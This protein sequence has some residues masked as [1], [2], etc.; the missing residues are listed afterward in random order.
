MKNRT[1]AYR[2]L[3]REIESIID[4]EDEAFCERDLDDYSY[5][6]DDDPDTLIR[7][8]RDNYNSRRIGFQAFDHLTGDEIA[9]AALKTLSKQ[10]FADLILKHAEATDC[11]IYVQ[12]NEVA[13]V[14]IGEYEYQI[15][16]DSESKLA[17]LIEACSPEERTDL[18]GRHFDGGS[19]L[20]YGCPCD[21]I[22]WK[23]DPETFLEGIEPALRAAGLTDPDDDNGE[24]AND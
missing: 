13:S 22:V 9:D 6:I 21:R 12:W 11:D 16:V 15:D 23:V 18:L 10:S 4:A 14:S 2:A 7:N 24:H 1:D 5:A 8:F 19:F 20:A 3:Q 17:A